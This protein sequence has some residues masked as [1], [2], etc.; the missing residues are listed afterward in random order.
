MIYLKGTGLIK[1]MREKRTTLTTQI[2]LCHEKLLEEEFL[3]GVSLQ[4]MRT[5]PW[6][7]R[8]WWSRWLAPWCPK[9]IPTRWAGPKCQTVWPCTQVHPIAPKWSSSQLFCWF[10][11][12]PIGYTWSDNSRAFWHRTSFKLLFKLFYVHLRTRL[13]I[14]IQVSLNSRKYSLSS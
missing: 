12:V 1:N 10:Q 2:S 3:P 4:N 8:K 13:A 7:F 5:S 11:F 14:K 6:R 9:N